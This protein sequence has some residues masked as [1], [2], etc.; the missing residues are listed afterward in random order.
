[1]LAGEAVLTLGVA[2]WQL[3]GLSS[4]DVDRP[5]VA[6]GSSTWFVLVAVVVAAFAVFAWRGARWVYGPAVFLQ[7]LALPMAAS[8]AVEGLWLGTV[9][10]GGMALAGLL[11]LVP[12]PG[13]QAFGRTDDPSPP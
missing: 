7:V 5:E 6:A 13:R 2:V 11:L 3:L 9:V 8:M 10:L 4:G 12:E 1:M